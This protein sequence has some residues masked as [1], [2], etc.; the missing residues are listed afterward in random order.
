MNEDDDAINNGNCNIQTN[1]LQRREKPVT[2]R[3]KLRNQR[4]GPSR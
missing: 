2:R 3:E 1:Q 4:P